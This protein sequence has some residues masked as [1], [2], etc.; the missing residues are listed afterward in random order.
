MDKTQTCI[1]C[2][3]FSN[4]RVSPYSI[5]Y[6]CVRCGSFAV[7]GT[8][9]PVLVER[10]F[11]MPLRRS[12]M[13]HAL[14]RMQRK[15]G[16]PIEIF[17]TDL[18]SYWKH[19]QLP[20]PQQQAQSLVLWIGDHQSSPAEPIEILP[21]PLAAWLGVAL[22]NRGTNSNLDWLLSEMEERLF[23][24]HRRPD[25]KLSFKLTMAGWQNYE[26]LRRSQITSRTAFMA[27]KFGDRELDDVVNNCFR[28]AVKRAGFELRILTDNQR[29]G[30][31]DDQIRAAL[32]SARFV[33]ADLTHGSYGA[34][35]EA[36]F[37]EG[38]N[39][40][41]IYTCKHSVWTEQK[42]HFDTNHMTTILWDSTQLKISE[43]NLTSTI[44][45]TLRSEAAQLDNEEV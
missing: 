6:D 14:R 7:I 19:D 28:N 16:E 12:L 26:E 11:N 13:S 41:V 5:Q 38:L 43:D 30:L 24:Q 4:G 32:L 40:P 36:G 31:I 15:S 1:V 34:Y 29:A 2:G 18:D 42:T 3:G 39:L 22:S 44:R 10:L 8:A 37:A 35:W 21:E 9:A 23:R 27:M 33:V 17:E 25:G 45:A 20:T